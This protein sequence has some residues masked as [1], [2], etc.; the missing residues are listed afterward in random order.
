[1]SSRTFK[2][3]HSPESAKVNSKMA[4]DDGQAI[5]PFTE[6]PTELQLMIMCRLSLGTL[7]A[8][9]QVCSELNLLAE[10]EEIW[11]S[12]A[13]RDFGVRLPAASADFSPKLFYRDV[14]HKY[15]RLLGLWQRRNLK[16]YG[17]LLRVSARGAALVFEEILPPLGSI[18]GRLRPV[19]FLT[20]TKGRQDAA[21]RIEC[22]MSLY[23]CENV[24]IVVV[25]EEEKPV[26]NLILTDL[27]DHR[28]QPAQWQDR[29]RDFVTLMVGEE[30]V[31]GCI[32][33]PV[34]CLGPSV[35][36]IRIHI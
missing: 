7:C 25:K 23:A 26:L 9:T 19:P 21:V 30:Q 33:L 8:C 5:F 22:D 34:R 12:L 27:V 31:R 32:S 14:L 6:L 15:R 29:L 13:R 36:R 10:D 35:F 11:T 18:F 20:L 16:H 4:T 1:M 17:S 24:K 2:R 3:E 28:L